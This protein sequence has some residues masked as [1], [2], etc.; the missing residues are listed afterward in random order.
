[1]FQTIVRFI[2]GEP[3]HRLNQ[4]ERELSRQIQ[5]LRGLKVEDGR[6]SISLNQGGAGESKFLLSV[7]DHMRLQRAGEAH[8]SH[9]LWQQ[10]GSPPIGMYVSASCKCAQEARTLDLSF[11]QMVRCIDEHLKSNK[12]IR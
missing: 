12:R 8:I 3:G 9:S 5:S 6:V 4:E 7:S 10:L 11:S 1:M 2:F